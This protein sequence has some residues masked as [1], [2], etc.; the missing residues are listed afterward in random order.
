MQRARRYQAHHPGWACESP[1]TLSL[2][3][4][5]GAERIEGRWAIP[6][7]SQAGVRQCSAE[8]ESA[9]CARLCVIRDTE[10]RPVTNCCHAL[11]L[12]SFRAEEQP[13]AV[14]AKDCGD[15][16]VGVHPHRSAWA[17]AWLPPTVPADV[18]PAHAWP[19]TKH[20]SPDRFA[21]SMLIRVLTI[22]LAELT[23]RKELNAAGW[24]WLQL[25]GLSQIARQ[26]VQRAHPADGM[27]PGH[28]NSRLGLCFLRTAGA[29]CCAP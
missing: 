21:L 26:I 25:G 15:M 24:P 3:R 10:A 16:F 19:S 29:V 14:L 6:T 20:R 8:C 4:W 13:A 5:V 1:L 12:S 22:T 28:I 17:T 18:L 27:V 9:R 2:W 7:D 11:S 23:S